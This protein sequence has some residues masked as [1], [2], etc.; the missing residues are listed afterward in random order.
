MWPFKKTYSMNNIHPDKWPVS[1]KHAQKEIAKYLFEHF[2]TELSLPGDIKLSFN[3]RAEDGMY[4]DAT[5]TLHINLAV[6]E[7][8]QIYAGIKLFNTIAHEC[9]HAEQY[10]LCH[11]VQTGQVQ[12]GNLSPFQQSIINNLDHY[13]QI[14]YLNPTKQYDRIIMPL[15]A[16]PYIKTSAVTAMYCM[17]PSEC[18]AFTYAMALTDEYL[19]RNHIDTIDSQLRNRVLAGSDINTAVMTNLDTDKQMAKHVRQLYRDICNQNLHEKDIPL[20]VALEQAMILTHMTNN[21]NINQLKAESILSTEFKTLE[22]DRLTDMIH[23]MPERDDDE[24]IYEDEPDYV[25]EFQYG[26]REFQQ[27]HHINE[28]KETQEQPSH[29]SSSHDDDEIDIS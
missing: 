4:N 14:N 13:R 19:N 22:T 21:N 28:D 10:T 25:Q 27:T 24:V 23:N 29:E 12:Y 3:Y 9:K 20:F 7:E 1:N 6:L 2:S 5:K 17:Q 8:Y 26:T 15:D 16:Y 18:D 11:Q